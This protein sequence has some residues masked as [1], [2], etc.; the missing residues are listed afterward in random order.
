MLPAAAGVEPQAVNTMAQVSPIEADYGREEQKVGNWLPVQH[1]AAGNGVGLAGGSGGSFPV[2]NGVAGLGARQVV[3]GGAA[4]V[5][6]NLP[7]APSP[8][9]LSQPIARQNPVQSANKTDHSAQNSPADGS[10]QMTEHSVSTVTDFN[11]FK[12]NRL[13]AQS[14]TADP[15]VEPFD[16]KKWK[17]SR[18]RPGWLIKRLTGYQPV[19]DEYGCQYLG[20]VSRKPDRMS[21]DRSI[22]P[23]AGFLTWESM[24]ESD[25]LVTEVNV[26]ESTRAI[27]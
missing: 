6:G 11:D 3:T 2:G 9:L 24:M 7:V 4:S 15:S 19:E 10:A 8:S 22:F 12:R 17:R 14:G 23:F 16:K 20:V 25:L 27:A 26:H 1:G 5:T 13:N 21:A 18:L